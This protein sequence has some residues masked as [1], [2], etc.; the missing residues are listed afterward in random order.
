MPEF[1]KYIREFGI[2]NGLKIANYTLIDINGYHEPVVKYKEYRYP[3]KLIF[4]PDNDH[5][6]PKILL[7]YILYLTSGTRTI[8]TSY[9]NPY[10]CNFGNPRIV[11]VEMNGDVII[12]T[13]GHSY[14]I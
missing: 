3:I 14:R 6:N 9:G 1:D 2:F 5:V 11:K 8:Y 10:Q 7:E 4:S 12:Y 13:V